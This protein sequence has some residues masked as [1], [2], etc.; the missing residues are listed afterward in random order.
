MS[1]LARLGIY[2]AVGFGLVY[3]FSENFLALG[4]IMAFMIIIAMEA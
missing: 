1:F 4:L 3:L 2:L